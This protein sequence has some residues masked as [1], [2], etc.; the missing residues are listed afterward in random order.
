[1][2]ISHPLPASGI[3]ESATA[4]F[5]NSE[6]KS[7]RSMHNFRR[8]TNPDNK[9]E[10]AMARR[11]EQLHAALGE[12]EAAPAKTAG[13][14]N[15]PAVI[16]SGKSFGTGSLIITA[17]I[18]ALFGAGLMWLST[19]H[20]ATSATRAPALLSM[21]SP[22]AA[23]PALREAALLAPAMPEISD[24]TRVGELLEAWR[25][26]WA[27]RDI[28]GYLATYSQQFTPADGNS[29]D[30]W[31]AARSKKLSAGAP[32]DIQ[33]RELG[34]ERINADQFKATFLQDYAAGSYRE[35]ARTKTLLI[36]RENDG[37]KITKEW[38]AENKLATR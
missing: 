15:H 33:I 2:A 23:T 20:G 30:A 9:Q 17:M 34:I 12:P 26:A 31:V 5:G 6:S 27:Q 19:P 1:V 14:Q 18:S 13:I 37:W 11:L 28:A 3:I 4:L 36:A 25:N 22:P 32:I 21:P 16:D 24:K 38:M 7:I 10:R 8:Q 29:R 35:M